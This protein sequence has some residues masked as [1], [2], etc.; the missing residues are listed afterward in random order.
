[1]RRQLVGLVAAAM[2]LLLIAFLAPLVVLLIRDA[3]SRALAE[4]TQRAQL[5]AASVPVAA[6]SSL[7][8]GTENGLAG[9]VILADGRV[10]GVPVEHAIARELAG[11]C[12]TGTTDGDGAV[13]I[14]VPVIR[15]GA[16][17]GV[18]RMMVTTE[19]QRAGLAPLLVLVFSLSGGLLLTGV[20]LAERLGAGLLRSVT[21]LAGTA[22][23]VAAGDLTARVSPSGP[24]EIR[25][26]GSELN[27]LAVRVGY[28]VAAERRRTADL[29]HRLRTPL[30]ALRLDIDGLADRTAARRLGDDVANMTAAVNDVIHASRRLAPEPG[31]ESAD[32]GRVVRERATFWG[33]LAEDTERQI[34]VR[35][36]RGPLPVRAGAA[37]VEAA[38]D[39]LLGNVFAHTPAGAGLVVTAGSAPLGGAMLI[40]DDAGPGFP[41]GRVVERGRSGA[42]STGL[43]LDIARRCAEESG[44]SMRLNRSPLGGARVWL[45][46]GP[47]PR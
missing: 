41:D 23:R 46:L 13:E 18:V 2:C 32:L 28:L 36:E 34:T 30:T 16:C 42:A 44:G 20:L 14:L 40:V 35:V 7:S 19:A 10:L 15:E 6:G 37:A 45:H 22:D 38:L 25:R 9:S 3:G 8:G 31:S 47:P 11:Q 29:T 21:E 12:R 43:G 26:I 4:A 5:L 1:M 17:V 27:R 24:P 33:P 39:A